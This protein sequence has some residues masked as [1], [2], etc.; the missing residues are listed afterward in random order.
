[1]KHIHVV[2]ILSCISLSLLGYMSYNVYQ[3]VPQITSTIDNINELVPFV[4]ELKPDIDNISIVIE[5]VMDIIPDIQNITATVQELKDLYY[6]K[7]VEFYCNG[8]TPEY[9]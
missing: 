2:E 6:Y 4:S 1:M 7:N 3:I 5:D 9:R 8:S